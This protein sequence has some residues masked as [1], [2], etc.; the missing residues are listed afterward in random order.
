[1]DQKI[2]AYLEPGE[3]RITYERIRSFLP[4]L[5]CTQRNA[6]GRNTKTQHNEVLVG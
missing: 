5:R 6:V 3:F 2:E 4:D 1:M